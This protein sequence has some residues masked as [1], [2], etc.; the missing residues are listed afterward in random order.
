MKTPNAAPPLCSHPRTEPRKGYCRD[1]TV[2]VREI[3]ID[4]GLNARG[5][6]VHL[7]RR[8]FTREEIDAMPVLFDYRLAPVLFG[9]E[10]G[11][12]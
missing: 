6:G 8:W 5:P 9:R 4:C 3:C 1:G 7:K 2:Q 11:E 10:G 12:A